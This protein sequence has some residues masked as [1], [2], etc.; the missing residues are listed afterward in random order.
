MATLKNEIVFDPMAGSGTTAAVVKK[1]G[2]KSIVCD[3]S[4]EY[5]C[6]IENRLGIKRTI[7]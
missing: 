4:E 5:I 6:K 2:R 1:S 3:M 7:L